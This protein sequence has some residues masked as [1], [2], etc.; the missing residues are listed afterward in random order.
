MKILGIVGSPR[1]GGN[2]EALTEIALEE[3]AEE[4]IETELIHL[5][6]KKI[7][8]CDACRTC[9][10]TGECRIRDDF[11]AIHEEMVKA[12]GFIL[13]TPV[14]F[15][16]ATPLMTSLI[17]RCYVSRRSNPF[18][19]KVG[20]PIVVARRAGKNFTF[21]QLMFFFMIHGM[22]VPGSTY[23][24]VAIGDERG[25]VAGDEEGVRTI[26]NFGKKLAWLD[27]KLNA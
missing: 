17:S 2:T 19:N 8:P 14:W 12:D 15:G 1:R 10:T 9:R 6:G 5:A 11:Q 22:I 4:G 23:W 16:A 26:R 25:E 20:G 24:N 21:A 27:K 18:E 3:I 7:A 13:A